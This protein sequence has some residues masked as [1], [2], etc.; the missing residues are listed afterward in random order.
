MTDHQHRPHQRE[1]GGKA[2]L[3]RSSCLVLPQ[4]PH[5]PCIFPVLGHAPDTPRKTIKRGRAICQ[6]PHREWPPTAPSSVLPT[7]WVHY[8]CQADLF[9]APGMNTMDHGLFWKQLF[10][11]LEITGVLTCVPESS[12]DPAQTPPSPLEL[13]G[14]TSNAGRSARLDIIACSVFIGTTV[15][16]PIK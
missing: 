2:V 10:F 7:T 1:V 12:L 15:C 3:H 5:S 6:G 4:M 11:S 8:G 13:R 16:L 14:Y 9:L